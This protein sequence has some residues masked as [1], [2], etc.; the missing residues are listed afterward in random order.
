MFCCGHG[1]AL[2]PSWLSVG[3]RCA[4]LDVRDGDRQG[5][6]VDREDNPVVA[7]PPTKCSLPFQLDHVSAE[8]IGAHGVDC[9]EKTQSVSGGNVLEI[10]FGA[11]AEAD[12]P[13]HG[14]I[15]LG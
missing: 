13:F 8:R 12:D 14:A 10:F 2:L 4:P 5:L 9:R 7:D 6:E 1:D 3:R 11:V 15:D